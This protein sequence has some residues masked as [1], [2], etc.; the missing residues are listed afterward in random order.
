MAEKLYVR[1]ASGLVRE[2]SAFDALIYN[3][4]IMAPTAVYVYGIWAMGLFPGVD[5]P[6]TVWIAMAISIVVGLYYAFMSAVL[7]RTGGDYIWIS[8]LLHPALGFMM[9]FFL[10]NVLLAVAGSYIPWFIEWGIG[11]FFDVLG[12]SDLAST[13]VDPNVMFGIAVLY[14]ILI[15]ILMSRGV[16]V[17]KIFFWLFF[18]TI[19]VGFL[20]YLYFLLTTGVEGFAS[21]FNQKTGLDYQTIIND[22][23][24]QGMPGDFILTATLMGSMFTILNFLG[25]NS[26]VYIAG[27]VKEVRKSQLLAIIGAVVLFA[28]ITWLVYMAAYIGFGDK[29][30]A[31]LSY[32][33]V[34][35]G[36][37][38]LGDMP[39]FF[40]FLIKLVASPSI[41]ALVFLGFSAMTLSAILVYIFTSVRFV[42]AW[43]FDRIIP[44]FFADVDPKTGT[45]Y[46]ALLLTS[47]LAIFFQA[48]WIYTP[49][50]NYFAFIVLGWGVL[51]AIASVAGIILPFRR[52]DLFELAPSF[53]KKK[54]G[55]VPVLSVLGVLSFFIGIWQAWVG[56]TP[57]VVGEIVPEYIA[58]LIGIYVIALV[59]YFASS[60]YHKKKGIP[61]E[62]VFKEIPPA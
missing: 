14:Y 37:Y 44:S 51:T 60:L 5:L 29:F 42:F 27:E 47:L 48:L 18:V 12:Y 22:A 4:L 53:A 61:L 13:L 26:S 23:V 24:S 49:Y 55:G 31:A 40:H 10:M 41:S 15:T 20:T 33:Y 35:S 3:V 45:P 9:S 17:T 2:I 39:P 6:L 7:P 30:V 32:L 38:P 58:F 62:L 34:V 43:A 36:N 56:T 1:R 59:I 19:L 11:P 46:T 16:K 21:L 25:F 54:I 8:R 28:V 57:A 50:L 52:P